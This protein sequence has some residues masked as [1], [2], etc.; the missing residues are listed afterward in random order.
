MHSGNNQKGSVLVFMTLMIVLLMIMV[1]MG[2]DTGSLVYIR[3]QG[4]AAVDAA[5]LAA[6]QPPWSA[7]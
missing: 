6:V 1:G 4:Q 2:L 7:K 5:A 3:A